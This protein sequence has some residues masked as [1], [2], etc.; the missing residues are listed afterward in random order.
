MPDAEIWV[1][2]SAEGGVAIPLDA[3]RGLSDT[4]AKFDPNPYQND[5]HDLFWF[6]WASRREYGLRLAR[7]TRSQIWMAAFD[8]T[9]T[10]E[11]AFVPFWLPFQNMATA[12][13]IAQWVTRVERQSCTTDADCGGE[14]CVD[15]F[16]FESVPV[17]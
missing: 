17:F 12:N 13:H 8:P 10:G 1:I 16:C 4:W 15:G 11:P 14:F 2:P 7:D 9:R 3:I 6:A 5:G